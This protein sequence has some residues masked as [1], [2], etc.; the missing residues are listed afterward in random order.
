MEA[1]AESLAEALHE[2]GVEITLFRGAGPRKS[3]YDIVLPCIK[4]TSRFARLCTVFNHLGGWRIGLG[5]DIAIESFSYGV[6]LLWHV[7]K[8]YDIVHVQQGILALFLDRARR[9]G[10]LKCPILLGNGQKAPPEFLSRFPHLHFL[11]PYGMEEVTKC[12]EKKPGWRVIPNFVDTEVFSPG[13]KVASR[14][15]IGLPENDLIV[16]SVGMVDKQVK[17]MDYFIHE[18]AALASEASQDVHFVIA[19][20]RHSDSPEI[21]QLGKTLLGDKFSILFDLDRERMPHLY[22]SADVFVLCSPREAMPV[23]L[24]EAMS[25]GLPAICHAFPVMEWIVGN[26]GACVDMKESGQLQATLETFCADHSLRESAGQLA[27]EQSVG[28]FAKP[29]VAA[30]IIKMYEEIISNGR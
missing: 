1:W 27:R 26:G 24:I 15:M 29:R 8:G 30:S 13:D 22:R 9:L 16:L 12:V 21:E 17:R 14:R 20:A 10:L 6:Q 28:F 2:K 23:A 18:A 25:C 7:R 3:D 4:R 5:S 19:G 11:S